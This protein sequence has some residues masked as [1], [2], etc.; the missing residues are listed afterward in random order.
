[1]LKWWK[2]AIGRY[3]S[4]GAPPNGW[5]PSDVC[6]IAVIKC[7]DNVVCLDDLSHQYGMAALHRDMYQVKILFLA[8]HL[9]KICILQLAGCNLSQYT[10]CR[11]TSYTSLCQMSNQI[12]LL[13]D[14]G[15]STWT[16]V[17]VETPNEGNPLSVSNAG[18]S[19]RPR[20]SARVKRMG[21]WESV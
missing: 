18:V 20:S 12:I 17:A 1:V 13:V 19:R 6:E 9:G 4:C 3:P 5:H 16:Y 8:R 2:L 11:T 7:F 10:K 15:I 14:L 21:S